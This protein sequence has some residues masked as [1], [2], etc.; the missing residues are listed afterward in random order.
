M[1]YPVSIE[2][3]GP[4]A[5]FARPDTG[6]APTS[7]PAPTFSACVGIFESIARF[8]SGDAWI[9]P[10]KVE[11]CKR[12]GTRGGRILYQ[13]YA[14]NYGGPL[15]KSNQLT[16][17]ARMQRFA[18]ALSNVCYRVHGECRG[19]HANGSN[20]RHYLSN[21]FQKHLRL[22]RCLSTPVLGWKEFPCSYW[23]PFREEEFEVDIDLD[24]TIPSMLFGV[25]SAPRAGKY[26]PQFQQNVRIRNGVLN[27]VE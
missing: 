5:M 18:T 16:K 17:D 3:A 23:G 14:T 15:R 21:R 13:Q 12:R 1:F 10:T 2:V 19:R 25:W 26:H 8:R 6:S 27:F 9:V 11:I 22:G 4:L 20:P 7:Y 24:L